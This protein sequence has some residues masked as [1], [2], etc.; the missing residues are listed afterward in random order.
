MSSS[1]F[2]TLAHELSSV[3]SNYT[4][5]PDARDFLMKVYC[6]NPPQDDQ[7][8]YGPC[9][10]PDV[11]GI[12]QQI[13]IYFTTG[14]FTFAL[15][16]FPRLVLPMLYAH[17]AV[18]YSLMIAA[19]ISILGGELTQNDGVFVLVAVGS[20]CTIYLWFSA[21]RSLISRHDFFIKERQDHP[22]RLEVRL[23][24]LLCVLSMGF[25][26]AL[27]CVLFVPSSRIHFSQPSCNQEFGKRLVFNLAWALQYLREG[28]LGIV[29]IVGT[30]WFWRWWD[31]RQRRT[32]ANQTTN[33][34]VSVSSP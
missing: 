5:G 18:M 12:G 11:T 30:A 7:C 16:Y 34:E 24:K 4:D 8:P 10:N 1:T 29:W 15:V 14:T 26:I 31:K 28:F 21:L 2:T 19:L 32:P 6:L 22:N 25:E 20:P 13:S 17:L 27:I 23:L 9:P 3:L 33:M